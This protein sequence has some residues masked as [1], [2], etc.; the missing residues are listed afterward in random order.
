[1]TGNP[2]DHAHHPS[3]SFATD[4]TDSAG[5]TWQGRDLSPSGFETDT[6]AADPA[7]RRTLAESTDDAELMTALA[8]ARFLIPI[9]AEPTGIDDSGELAV[10][11]SVDMAA[12]TLVGPEGQRALPVFTGLDALLAWD[13]EARPVPVDAARIGQAAVGE[14]CEVVVIDVAGPHTRVLRPSM[15]WSLAVGQPWQPAHLDPFVTRAV[16]AAT[17]PEADVTAY[18]LEE[19]QPAGQGVLGVVLTLRPGLAPE[20]VQA[21]ATRVG[22]RL[23]TD[24]ELRARIDGLAFRL[25]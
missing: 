25:V 17:A 8:A 24:G 2:R 12:V 20:Q 14:Q 23:A 3:H 9:V 4:A 13:P 6:G 18:A 19:G 1:M 22:E 10:E 21:L 7:L 15:V 5:T 16:A 11:T